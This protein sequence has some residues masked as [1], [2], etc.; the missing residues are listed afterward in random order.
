MIPNTRYSK[1][2]YDWNYQSMMYNQMGSFLF[3]K[4]TNGNVVFKYEYG[5]PIKGRYN[6][7]AKSWKKTRKI[8]N[9]RYDTAI[10]GV[11]PDSLNYSE[12][13]MQYLCYIQT[14]IDYMS[15]SFDQLTDRI[16]IRNRLTF[17]EKIKLRNFFK[18]ECSDAR[19]IGDNL[20]LE[21][22]I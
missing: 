5:K 11:S 2:S 12:S 4:C 8:F 14:P 21:I 17:C 9:E 6:P 16:I 13:A 15:L 22:I 7:N 1:Y 10:R 20:L 18:K 3:D 19:I